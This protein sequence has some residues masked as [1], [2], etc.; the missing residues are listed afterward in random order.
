MKRF[1]LVAALLAA[2]SLSAG[3]VGNYPDASNPLVGTERLLADQNDISVNITPVQLAAFIFPGGDVSPSLMPGMLGDCTSTAGTVNLTC[4]KT[5]GVAFAASATTDT[6]V[7]TNIS[8]G[9]LPAARL[10][11]PGPSSLGGVESL[12][13]V[14]HNFLIGISTSGVPGAAQPSCSDLSNGAASCSTD[15]TNASNISAGTLPAARLPLPSASSLGGVQ[16]LAVQSHLFLNTISTSGIPGATQPSCADLSNGAASCSTDTT[17]ATN[18]GSGTLP[19]GRI[20]AT[21]VTASS[22]GDGSHVATFTVGA[23]GRLTAAA[24]VAI[25]GGGGSPSGAAGGDLGGTYPNPT[26]AQIN[27]AV[28]PPSTTAVAINSSRQLVAATTSGTGSTLVLATGATLVAPNLGTPASGTLTNATGLPTTGLTGTLQ[29]AQEPAHTGDCTNS[30]GSLVLACTKTGGVLFA[31]SA[32]TDTTVATNISSGTLPAGR[33]PAPTAIALGGVESLAAVSHNFLTSITTAGV[34]TQAQPSFSD[35]SGTLAVGGGGTGATTLTGPLKGNGTSAF[36]AAASADI[37]GLWSGTC[38]S[39]TYLNGA[40]TCTT[41]SGAGTV[42]TTGSPATGNLTQFSGAT[43][44]TN[45]NLS[46]DCTTSGT[47]AV[48]CLKTNGVAFGTAAAANTGTSG[49]TVPLLN[50]ANT[51]SAV[52]TFNDVN[53]TGTSVPA[54]AGINSCGVNTHTG[55]LCFYTAGTLVAVLDDVGNWTTNTGPAA[56]SITTGF[57]YLQAV[58]GVPGGVPARL[59]GGGYANPPLVQDNADFRLYQY[60]SGAWHNIGDSLTNAQATTLGVTGTGAPT[61]GYGINQCGA[62]SETCLVANGVNVLGADLNGNVLTFAPIAT[63]ATNGFVYLTGTAGAPTGTPATVSGGAYANPPTVVDTTHGRLYEYTGGWVNVADSPTSTTGTGATVRAT[64]PTLTTPTLGAATATS[65]NG[66][67]LTTGTW[68]LTGAS[69]RTLTFNNSLTFSGTDSTTFTFPSVSGT[70]MTLSSAQ[71]ITA[72]K[73]FTNSD[74]LLLGSSTGTTTLASANTGSSNF[75][76]T[77]PALTDAIASQS[78]QQNQQAVS[79]TTVAGDA[80]WEIYH[81]STS[82]HTFTI[83]ANASVPYLIGTCIMLTNEPAGGTITIAMGGSD[84]LYFY[85]DTGPRSLGPASSAVACK[86]TTNSWYINGYGITDLIAPDAPIWIGGGY[87]QHLGF[88][89]AANAAVF[90][91]RAAA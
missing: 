70:V 62:A 57:S 72:A 81:V 43:S 49:G 42:I 50:A 59:T 37:I 11:N 64:S 91:V 48:T 86:K 68:T 31:A 88:G 65:I 66:N 35:I 90:D 26:V 34:P 56:T 47:L 51:Y 52:Q 71:T 16:S 38:T 29:A 58:T 9:T 22:Y 18:I 89:T 27:G 39:G 40:G 74:L 7:A 60:A 75:T 41:P 80:G 13:P 25:T 67:T 54:N 30:A 32:T 55:Q 53:L 24:S 77:F 20:P 14:T 33:L 78:I 19:A 8:S 15:A 76:L 12:A 87:G 1:L 6:T 44:I 69:G 63:N 73:T 84:F 79:Y 28:I 21:A 45:G 10:P 85:G 4:L 61:G 82:P 2:G 83:A 3:E 5:N 46:G 36:T 23:D 17:N